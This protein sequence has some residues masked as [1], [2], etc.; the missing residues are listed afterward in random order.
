MKFDI[1]SHP[2]RPSLIEIACLALE[3]G[4]SDLVES[5]MRGEEPPEFGPFNPADVSRA[6]E[7]GEKET[8]RD[9]SHAWTPQPGPQTYVM[10]SN[11]P[12]IFLGGARGGGKTDAIAGKW[13]QHEQ[14]YG[15]AARGIVIRQ[16][17]DDLED[18][19]RRFLEIFPLVGAK[20]NASKRIFT[21]PSGARFRL[22]HAKNERVALRYKGKSF[23]FLAIEEAQ[24]W[25]SLSFAWIV[26]SS[27]RSPEGVPVFTILT[28]NP[29]GP[30]QGALMERYVD[31]K[32]EES[33]PLV[34]ERNGASHT[35][36]VLR[37][38][39]EATGMIYEFVPAVLEDNPA[40]TKN[41]P[42]YETRL[43]AVGAALY[44]A[45]RHGDWS[46]SS[47]SFFGA[48]FSEKYHVLEPFEIPPEWTFA[49][50]F[51]WGFSKPAAVIAAA[52]SDGSPGRRRLANGDIELVYL[53]AGSV[54]VFDE[55]YTISTDEFGREIHNV[56]ARVDNTELGRLIAERFRSIYFE[57]SVA[58][59]SIFPKKGSKSSVYEEMKEGGDSIEL[60]ESEEGV[61]E[62]VSPGETSRVAGWQKM[63]DL[64]RGAAD[65]RPER[66]GL[67]FMRGRARH[68]VRTLK[69]APV[70]PLKK[71]DVDTTSEDH[72]LDAVRYL[73][74]SISVPRGG[75]MERPW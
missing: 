71:D 2:R 48:E 16:I 61:F 43:K 35:T 66:P 25:P 51:D 68:L 13:L 7:S 45:W 37:H 24:D 22:S 11:A 23:N 72:A 52:I 60:R 8:P 19:E 73:L 64:L 4:D 56:G 58:D 63:I 17:L 38:R 18:L 15:R 1:L 12:E 30:G 20:Y 69:N 28:G 59:P 29:G 31:H 49:R 33:I 62:F 27:L 32:P 55:I 26:S 67:Y 36:T 39:D 74:T 14:R 65:P 3:N 50:G 41:D 9:F 5:M 46:S 40:L 21:F 53:P 54:V 57:I 10:E 75:T 6:S 34:Y 47:G 42:N 70:S 44:R